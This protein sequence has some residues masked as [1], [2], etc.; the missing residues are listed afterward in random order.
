MKIYIKSND[1][2]YFSSTAKPAC[3]SLFKIFYAAKQDK[4]EVAN[5]KSVLSFLSQFFHSFPHSSGRTK[6]HLPA[7]AHVC[8][9]IHQ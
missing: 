2:C 9:A 4:V 3:K 1:F 8:P 7:I 6:E 5:R